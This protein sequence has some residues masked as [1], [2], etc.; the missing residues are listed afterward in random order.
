MA[1][2]VSDASISRHL[3]A[4]V[5]LSGLRAV[6]LQ[7]LP[8]A[9]PQ[10]VQG[11]VGLHDLGHGLRDEGLHPREPVAKGAVQVVRQVNANHHTCRSSQQLNAN[12]KSSV[13]GNK[14]THDIVPAHSGTVSCDVVHKT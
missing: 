3:R 10:H 2:L 5:G 8:D 9:L 14:I 12:T 13:L 4:E 6:E 7:P 11:G 1:C